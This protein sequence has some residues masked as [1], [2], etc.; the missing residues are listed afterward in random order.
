LRQILE[1]AMTNSERLKT[2][3]RPNGTHDVLLDGER[4]GWMKRR[5]RRWWLH[6][7]G[8]YWRAA[9]PSRCN[10]MTGT[11]AGRTRI[12]AMELASSV[13]LP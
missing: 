11:Y 4:R 13:L 8:W 1:D 10:G 3:R 5:G 12:E 2:R 9:G 6:L 7:D